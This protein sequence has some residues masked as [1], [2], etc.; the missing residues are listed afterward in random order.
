MSDWIACADRMPDDYTY[1]LVSARYRRDGGWRQTQGDMAV[2]LWGAIGDGD[3]SGWVLSGGEEYPHCD[4][5]TH[6]MPLPA[7]PTEETP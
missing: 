3:H 1:V 6:W 2:G 7:V 5:V 4:E